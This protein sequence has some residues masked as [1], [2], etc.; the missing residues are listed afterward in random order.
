M[1]KASFNKIRKDI[2][3]DK[4]LYLFLLLP[5]VYIIIF[6]YVPMGGIIIAFED[7]SARKGIFGSD[8]VGF[9]HFIRFF[10]SYECERVIKNTLIL[11]V[12]GL[13]AGFPIPVCFAL[14]LNSL[15]NERL[16]KISQTITCLPNFIS[17][18]V[19]VGI[20]YQ[21]FNA[22]NGL[23]GQIVEFV[24]GNYPSDLFSSGASFRN[25]YV[26]SGVWQGFGW[27]SI[28]Y[29]AALAGVDP[30]YYDAARIDGASRFQRVRYI[31]LPCIMPTIVI[32]LILSM[33]NIMSVGFEK[34]FLMQNGLNLEASSIIST[35]VYEM[36]LAS[37]SAFGFSYSTA[38]GIFNSVVNMAM[39]LL[40]N[41]ISNRVT[42]TGLW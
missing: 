7:Y 42:G 4:Q 39:L 30:E 19:M 28:I 9:K 40:A 38:I 3:R 15:R 33:G 14:V 31:D 23:Y 8:W 21:I 16:K 22:R 17:T 20:L 37:S 35:Y 24:T 34:V 10:Q 26:W 13:I 18:A 29:T 25:M 11:S 6:A 41:K 36:G 5:L 2:W 12:Y 32:T 27:G 1:K